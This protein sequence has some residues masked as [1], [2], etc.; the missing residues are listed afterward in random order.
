MKTDAISQKYAFSTP[1][2]TVTIAER[3]GALAALAFSGTPHEGDAPTPLL[4]ETK[5]QLMEYFAG[6]RR[7]FSLPL[8][9]EGT[10][11]QHRVWDVLRTIPYGQTRTYGEVAR[12]AGA[13]GAS[14]ACGMANNRNPIS[15]IIPCHRVVG[16]GGR[17]TGYGGGLG[18]KAAVLRIERAAYREM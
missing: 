9:P 11:W 3:D 18:V 7:E 16:V 14:R 4:A 8:A 13:P 2:G 15:I 1:V 6:Q 5:R 17:L 10:P 12:L